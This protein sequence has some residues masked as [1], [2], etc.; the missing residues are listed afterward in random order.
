MF[1][2]KVILNSFAIIVISHL[3]LLAQ[4]SLL[5]QS[6]EEA[7]L[8]V[9]HELFDAYRAGDSARVSRVFAKEAVMQRAFTNRAGERVVTSPTSIATF[10]GYIGG[11]LTKLHD[12]R[13]W[14]TVVHIDQHLA[15]VWTEYAFFLDKVFTHC[16]AE[17][18]LLEKVDGQWKI[19][20]LIDTRKVQTCVVPEL[21]T[22]NATK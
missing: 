12:E 20:H 3:S 6:D 18:F 7:I 13:L 5:P 21:I 14:N 16:G 1:N 2:M 9:V 22:V 17:N 19:F 10:V 15:S 4:G 8:A 11:G